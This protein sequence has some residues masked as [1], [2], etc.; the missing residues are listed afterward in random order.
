MSMMAYHEESEAEVSEMNKIK[1]QL[2]EIQQDI[3]GISRLQQEVAALL[4]TVRELQNA[5]KE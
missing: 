3:A 2:L 4:S 1:Q 5:N